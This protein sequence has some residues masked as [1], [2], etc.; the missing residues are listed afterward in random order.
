[1]NKLLITSLMAAAMLAACGKSEDAK[2]TDPAAKQ[3]AAEVKKDAAKPAEQPKGDQVT[4]TVVAP[5]PPPPPGGGKP[6][7]ELKPEDIARIQ[8]ML[9]KQAAEQKD[10][11]PAEAPKAAKK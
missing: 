5:K 9:K 3:P 4:P 1:M 10:A 8:E 6:A 7:P 2:P 11:K